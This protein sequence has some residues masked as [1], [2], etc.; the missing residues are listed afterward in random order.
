MTLPERLA[1][2][3]EAERRATKGPWFFYRN[4]DEECTVYATTPDRT[5]VAFTEGRH[6]DAELIRL[7]RNL[8]PDLL[9]A[10]DRQRELLR[11]AR[12]YVAAGM[13]LHLNRGTLDRIDAELEG[14]T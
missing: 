8:L 1:A 12:G 7:A 4:I 11:E 10:Y 9:A 6:G 5:P 14:R 13:V 2:L 3:R